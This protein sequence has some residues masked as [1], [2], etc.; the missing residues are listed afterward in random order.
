MEMETTTWS[1]FLN[2]EK[3]IVEQIPASEERYK[4]KRA[5]LWESESGIRV[6]KLTIWVR[7]FKIE[8]L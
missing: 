6:G 7:P 5:G 4:S 1:D 3:V 8:T 2:G